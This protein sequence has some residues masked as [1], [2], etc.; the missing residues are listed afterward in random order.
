MLAPR[1]AALKP[2]LLRRRDPNSRSTLLQLESLR[3]EHRHLSPRVRIR[4]TVAQRTRGASARD[5]FP[6]EPLDPIGELARTR[7][8]LEHAGARGRRVRGSVLR[9]QEE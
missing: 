9:L 1:A 3:Q 2:E 4:R 6:V 5:A 7:D 8:V